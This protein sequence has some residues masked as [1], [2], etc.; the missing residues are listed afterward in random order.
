MSPAQ[1]AARERMLDGLRRRSPEAIALIARR[2]LTKTVAK[3]LLPVAA[4]LLLVALAAAPSLRAGPAANRV[5]YHVQNATDTASRMQGARYHGVDQHGQP[6]TLTADTANQLTSD[7]VALQQPA[8]DITLK[9]GAWL[10]LHSDAGLYHQKSQRLG[11]HGNVT[12]YRNDGTMMSSSTA[13]I[14]LRSGSASSAAPVQVQGPFGTLNAA[15]GFSL[16]DRG[17]DVVFNGPATLV[18][19]QASAAPAQ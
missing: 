9:S 6:F 19:A 15:N 1:R 8:G 2:S 4:V 17:A 10:E 3:R 13:D 7:Q 12:L 5:T 14:D 18:L 11:L 16:S